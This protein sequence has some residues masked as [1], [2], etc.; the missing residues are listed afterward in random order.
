MKLVYKRILIFFSVALNIGF[1]ATALYH[2]VDN[3]LP[4][5]ERRW[6]DLMAIVQDLN[7]PSEKA[8]EVTT[9]MAGFRDRIDALDK[10]SRQT[11]MAAMDLMAAPGPLD[12]DELQR[13]MQSSQQQTLQ[14][15]EM[16]EA[17]VLQ[18]REVLG[19][20]KGA[21]FFQRLRDHIRS[22]RKFSHN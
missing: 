19:D 1:L 10:E 21:A 14:K 3:T 20:D 7:L 2:S 11:R 12:R 15:K 9:L 6:Q 13:L 5:K 22:K 16:F 18:V 17:H 4:R 8:A